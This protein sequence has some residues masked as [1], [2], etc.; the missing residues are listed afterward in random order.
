M[1]YNLKRGTNQMVYAFLFQGPIMHVGLEYV[2][3]FFI[4]DKSRILGTLKKTAAAQFIF[5]FANIVTF[6][7]FMSLLEGSSIQEA[8]NEVNAKFWPT[9]V[10]HYKYWPFV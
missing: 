5:S 8:K 3:P 7:F 2:V 10:N 4:M 6:Y 9:Y 1:T